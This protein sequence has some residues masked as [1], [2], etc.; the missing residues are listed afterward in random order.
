LITEKLIPRD[1]VENH[2]YKIE[3]MVSGNK[4]EITAVPIEYGKTGRTSFFV[5]E[6][7][8]VRGGDHG[9][10]PATISDKPVQ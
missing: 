7:K 1:V 6:S 2:G 8:V 5:D 3:V 4:F 10:G 9:G